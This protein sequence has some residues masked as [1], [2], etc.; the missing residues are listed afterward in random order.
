NL[1]KSMTQ[2]AEE[3]TEEETGNAEGAGED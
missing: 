1:I 2:G 3:R